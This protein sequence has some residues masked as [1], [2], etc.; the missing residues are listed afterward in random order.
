MDI[1]QLLPTGNK[2]ASS[3]ATDSVANP[4]NTSLTADMQNA[5]AQVPTDTA[6]INGVQTQSTGA[7]AQPAS[8]DVTKMFQ[9]GDGDQAKLNFNPVKRDKNSMAPDDTDW[10]GQVSSVL[11]SGPV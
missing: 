10:K 2:Q 11:G 4:A 8:S 7:N 5:A 6:T 1:N 9:N 3:G